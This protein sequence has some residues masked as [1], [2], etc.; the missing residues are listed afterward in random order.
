MRYSL[1]KRNSRLISL[2]L[3]LT[4]VAALFT[5]CFGSKT[6]EETN[7]SEDSNVPP[8]LVDVKPTETQP[9]P[10]ETEPVLSENSAVVNA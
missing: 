8:G 3:V 4:L 2:L 10:T 1:T 6:P 9:E 7:P 5:G